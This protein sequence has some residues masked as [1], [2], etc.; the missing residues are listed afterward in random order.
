MVRWLLNVQ[1]LKRPLPLRKG[2]LFLSQYSAMVSQE[3]ELPIR[4]YSQIDALVLS[5]GSS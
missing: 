3:Q 5:L 1:L 2:R 4:K